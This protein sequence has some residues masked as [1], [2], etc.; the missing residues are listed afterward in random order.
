MKLHK[1]IFISMLGICLLGLMLLASINLLG[2]LNQKQTL[3]SNQAKAEKESHDSILGSVENYAKNF[4]AETNEMCVKNI[5]A[6]LG[7][8]SKDVTSMKLFLEDKYKNYKLDSSSYEGNS[9]T[10]APGISQESISQ[11][12]KV[13][14]PSEISF[15]NILVNDK[16]NAVFYASQSGFMISNLDMDYSSS[17]SVDRRER[18]WYK[19]AVEKDDI[20]WTN[21]YE[22]LLTEEL[23]VTCSAPV[24]WPNKKLAGVVSQD[25]ELSSITA[26]VLNQKNEN[27]ELLFLLDESL[28]FIAD[29]NGSQNLSETMGK[30]KEKKFIELLTK[31]NKDSENFMEDNLV[32]GFSKIPNT[33]W[34]FGIIFEYSQIKKPAETTKTSIEKL[35]KQS[36][37]IINDQIAKQIATNIIFLLI[38]SVLVLIISRLISL[39][40]TKPL[41]EL[42]KAAQIVSTGKLEHKIKIKSKDEIGKLSESFN[43]MT[44]ELKKQIKEVERVTL[45][46]SK[47]SAELNIAS[48]IQK[49]MLPN[50]FPDS[51][52][53]KQVDIFALMDPAKEVGGD[54]Y[55]FF[56]IGK[57]NI[58][59]VIADVSGKGVPAALF[60]V[61]AKTLIKDRLQGGLS[62]AKTLMEVNN[63]LCE[64]NGAEMFLTCFVATLDLKTGKL[65]Y[66]NAG[67]NRPLI[68]K[69]ET[70]FTWLETKPKIVLASFENIKFLDEETTMN[71]GDSLFLYT[72]GVT[73]ALNPQNELYSDP[74]LIETLNKKEI[75][76]KS[77]KEI[78]HFVLDSITNFVDKAEQ[79]DDITMLAFNIK[80]LINDNLSEANN[81]L[82]YSNNSPPK[83]GN[84]PPEKLI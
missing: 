77:S 52:D 74:R 11:E 16:K 24:Y 67:H 26:N 65:R 17:Y 31:S 5:N 6:K 79:S 19:K 81:S 38:L 51:P 21:V 46:K 4:V 18:D 37:K 84:N 36:E 9:Y 58:A 20:F 71:K 57:H 56:F 61:I 10:I 60:M 64:N 28:S 54:F 1:K 53:H 23:M 3:M 75:E 55:D 7:E 63:I 32:A 22:D 73:E 48:T 80:K 27:I 83:I 78:L 66:S 69:K 59:F 29:S 30:E 43:H 82:P 42:E 62:S 45:E 25:I 15:N 14:K 13:I 35:S 33:N 41:K 39:S 2:V 40:I 72:D 12:L 49:S 70:G 8:I 47:V 76:G 68:Y 44:S 50:V 34:F